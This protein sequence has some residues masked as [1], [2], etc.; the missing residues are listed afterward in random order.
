VHQAE[1]TVEQHDQQRLAHQQELIILGHELQALEQT[2]AEIRTVRARQEQTYSFI[3][4]KGRFGDSRQPVYIECQQ[5]QLLFHPQQE[6][7]VVSAIDP[8]HLG[9]LLEPKLARQAADKKPYLFFIV[10]PDGIE[11]YYRTLAML[12]TANVDYGYEFV[13]RDWVLDFSDRPGSMPELARSRVPEPRRA[14]RNFARSTNPAGTS[15]L[16]NGPFVADSGGPGGSAEGGLGGGRGFGTDR[17]LDAPNNSQ[18]QPGLP[19]G[20]VYG[21]PDRRGVN[22]SVAMEASGGDSLAGGTPGSSLS[23]RAAATELSRAGSSRSNGSIQSG[24]EPSLASS[25]ASAAERSSN[26]ALTPLV[27]MAAN[28]G[29]RD[30]LAGPSASLGNQLPGQPSGQRMA[31]SAHSAGGGSA[32]KER[33]P[34][35]QEGGYQPRVTAGYSGDERPGS[36]RRNA[37]VSSWHESA[38]QLVLRVECQR[39]QLTMTPPGIRIALAG[40]SGATAWAETLQKRALETIARRQAM[41]LPDEP[42]YQPVI[43]FIVWPEGLRTYY[44]AYPVLEALHVPMRREDRRIEQA[45]RIETFR[46]IES[47]GQN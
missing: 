2:L 7:L 45:K 35:N 46:P 6:A 22:G 30:Q 36:G 41:V 43:H 10:R 26:P 25:N 24:A 37:A 39:D 18:G 8:P 47:D 20:R 34:D 42:P 29:M 16:P 14:A 28:G 15:I 40:D 19:V 31:V 32:A 21:P 38:R 23:R 1:R 12:R 5:H 4:Y 3:P 11:T 17:R 9:A 13:E 44:Q 33:E 27:G